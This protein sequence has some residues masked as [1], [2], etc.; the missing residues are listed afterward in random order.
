MV[1][2]DAQ[3]SSEEQLST[4]LERTIDCHSHA[5]ASLQHSNHTVHKLLRRWSPSALLHSPGQ[6][7]NRDRSFSPPHG[8]GESKGVQIFR[9]QRRTMVNLFLDVGFYFV[10][11]VLIQL[12]MQETWRDLTY[13]F[14]QVLV[15]IFNYSQK[16]RFQLPSQPRGIMDTGTLMVNSQYA[17]TNGKLLRIR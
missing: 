6:P 3:R 17:P 15:Q 5:S 2:K 13:R 7:D 1:T 9:F 16:I 12:I 10:L 14:Q 4:Q 11:S 8:P